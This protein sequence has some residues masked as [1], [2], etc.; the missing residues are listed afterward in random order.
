M[1][2]LEVFLII[3]L[4]FMLGVGSYIFWTNLPSEPVEFKEY[5]ASYMPKG[6]NGG[7]FYPN[8]R[9]R[10]K[11]ITYHIEDI[12]S[13]KN[14]NDVIEAFQMLDWLTEIDFEMSN[15]G[16]INVFCSQ[17]APEPE[18]RGHF[19]AGEGGPSEVI[20]TS[21]YSVIFSGKISLYRADSCEKPQ[22]AIHEILHSLGFDHNGNKESIM[23][24]TTGCRQEIDQYIINKINELYSV[25]SEPDLAIEKVSANASG[26]YLNFEIVVINLGLK[27]SLE[28]VLKIYAEGSEIKGF[29]LKDID[30]GTRK[31]LSVQNVRIP[32]KTEEIK[33]LIETSE[34]ELSKDNN[35]ASVGL[36]G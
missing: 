29:E 36:V 26:R 24:P 22:I 31:V 21:T 10:N 6:D 32:A 5:S 35:E 2:L 8:M 1:N 18:E 25:P 9:Y 7:Q 23:Y 17:I 14:R 11:K 19:V 15:E 16:E 4:F 30:I 33:F 27:S 13:K 12:C 20:N 3:L 34:P 28:S